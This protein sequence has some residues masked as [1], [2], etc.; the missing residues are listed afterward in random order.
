MSANSDAKKLLDLARDHGFTIT[1]AK[2]GGY[3]IS[4]NGDFVAS[5]RTGNS[6]PPHSVMKARRE[7]LKRRAA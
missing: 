4:D 7:M 2:H 6:Q 1:K 5:V 3:T